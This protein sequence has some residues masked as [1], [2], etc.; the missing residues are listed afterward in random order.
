MIVFTNPFREKI[1]SLLNDEKYLGKLRKEE[2]KKRMK[3][4]TARSSRHGK[5][6]D[7]AKSEF[8]FLFSDDFL[9]IN[10]R[11]SSVGRKIFGNAPIDALILLSQTSLTVHTTAT[12]FIVN[13]KA[14]SFGLIFVSALF[15][16]S[17][18]SSY[19][20]TG[21]PNG[22]NFATDC[23]EGHCV[24][25]VDNELTPE[26]KELQAHP[27]VVVTD[28]FGMQHYSKI[29]LVN[30]SPMLWA[31]AHSDKL[32]PGVYMI[33][34]TSRQNLFKRTLIIQAQ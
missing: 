9:F 23:R 15:F 28:M 14:I 22:E 3:A 16:L 34:S 18:T 1:V 4:E 10:Q 2:K 7:S 5:L 6:S 30:E 19:S 17:L 21:K 12:M 31:I 11:I 25:A 27:L 32:T 33:T 29:E 24:V 26:A 20:F 13:G 8:F